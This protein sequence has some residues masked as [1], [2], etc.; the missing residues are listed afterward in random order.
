[1]AGRSTIM[2]VTVM[3]WAWEQECPTATTKLVLLKLA[4]NA[5]DAGVCWPSMATIAQHCGIA[6]E[7]VVRTIKTLADAGLL[8][9]EH[10]TAEGVKLPNIYHLPVA[11]GGSDE[12]S[13]PPPPEGGVV[14]RDHYQGQ[15]EGGSD[16]R[17]LAWI[18]MEQNLVNIMAG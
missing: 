1:M 17:S 7:T 9:I 13:L 14:T 11:R 6:R 18:S 8:S 10:R 5:N 15:N 2:S 12:R 4:D 3:S 16:E